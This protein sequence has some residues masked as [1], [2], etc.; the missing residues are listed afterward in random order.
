M[1]A[2][3]SPM[4]KGPYMML[5]QMMCPQPA[6]QQKHQGPAYEKIEG[7]RPGMEAKVTTG[8][9]AMK[10][11]PKVRPGE[12]IEFIKPKLDVTVI[13]E[14][15]QELLA[16]VLWELTHIKPCM[17]LQEF[18]AASYVDLYSRFKTTHERLRSGEKIDANYHREAADSQNI[19]TNNT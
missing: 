3:E 6:A 14:L 10:Q 1:A 12:A 8:G 4:M 9:V 5:P 11:M 18:R 15:S 7:Y 2:M 19:K 16:M 17:K 13:G